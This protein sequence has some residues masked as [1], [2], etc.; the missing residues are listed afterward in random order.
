MKEG[1]GE[2]VTGPCETRRQYDLSISGLCRKQEKRS[3]PRFSARRASMR[4][5]ATGKARQGI[6]ISVSFSFLG[7]HSH[8][9]VQQP[10]SAYLGGAGSSPVAMSLSTRLQKKEQSQRRVSS[11][12]QSFPFPLSPPLDPSSRH[13]HTIRYPFFPTI[14]PIPPTQGP[15]KNENSL[16]MRGH[17]K[18]LDDG[19]PGQVPLDPR[20]DRGRVFG[21]RDTCEWAPEDP[22]EGVDVGW[23]TKRTQREGEGETRQD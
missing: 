14:T 19:R 13:L 20:S 22:R 17:V 1:R 21:L 8:P 6:R 10:Y 16:G 7:I 5:G 12:P 23:R 15:Q 4:E 11:P 2:E 18:S 3:F 9:T